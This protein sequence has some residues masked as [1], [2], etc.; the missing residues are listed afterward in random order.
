[1]DPSG[2][3][4]AI[5]DLDGT[6]F[7]GH[8][9]QA[10]AQHHNSRQ[11]NRRWLYVYMATHLPLWYFRKFHLINAE[12]ARYISARNMS[13]LLRG[14]DQSQA[15]DMFI[16]IRDETIIP[17]PR[18]D[19]MEQLRRHQTD[20]HRVILLSGAYHG[21]LAVVGERLGVHEALGT[22]LLKRNGRHLGSALAPIC[23]G[24]GKLDR[25]QIYLSERGKTIDLA[26]SYAY[27]DSITDRYLL[28]SVGHPTAVYPDQELADLARQ[29]RWP[30]L[31]TTT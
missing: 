31:G 18:Q 24:R 10:V 25:L 12:R 6:L 7:S 4:A 2:T 22:R 13:W 5:F 17:L 1:M 27:A 11:V 20:G 28:A 26:G 14:F 19:V 21:L 29:I 23:Q 8:I 3:T 9:W 15:T 30:I 16:W